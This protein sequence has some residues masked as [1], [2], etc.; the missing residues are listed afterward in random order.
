M[1]ESTP[2]LSRPATRRAVMGGATVLIAAAATGASAAAP[3]TAMGVRRGSP[4]TQQRTAL[5]QEVIFTAS[6]ARIYAALLNSTAFARFTGM[7]AQID[8]H[9]G[10]A[11]SLFGGLVVGRNIELIPEKRIVQA[12]RAVEDFPSGVYSV[13]KMEFAPSD[14]GTILMLD[15]TGFP[16]GHYEHLYEGWPPR[17]W[18]PLKKYLASTQSRTPR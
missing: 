3:T 11:I 16:E 12:W 17:Y 6:P 4:E 14:S 1:P 2:P 18:D 15:H 9:V 10:G 13:V 7:P 5:H 8:P